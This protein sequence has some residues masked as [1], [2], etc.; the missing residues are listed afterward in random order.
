MDGLAR[1][2]RVTATTASTWSPGSGRPATCGHPVQVLRSWHHDSTSTDIDSF[3]SESG[4]HPFKGRIVVSTTDHW[5][6]NAEQAIENQQIP[7]SRLRFRTSR[8][9]ASTGRSSTLSTP[10]VMEL[11]DKKQLRPHQ[12]AA[13]DAVRAGF[14]AA[15]RGKL[16]MACGT[17]KTFTLAA[18]R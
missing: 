14:A 1:P 12:A 3:F 4:K 13:L 7:V 2:A 15:D 9:P 16:I 5:G 10:E 8:S 18:H 6:K 17:G 11:K